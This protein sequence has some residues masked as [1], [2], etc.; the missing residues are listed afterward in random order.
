MYLE[1]SMAG[2]FCFTTAAVSFVL[3]I[4]KKKR[5]YLKDKDIIIKGHI[6]CKFSETQPLIPKN[7]LGSAR[8]VAANYFL[9]FISADMAHAQ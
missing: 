1:F 2:C 6:V 7:K 5:Q 9:R 3:K 8:F 4:E